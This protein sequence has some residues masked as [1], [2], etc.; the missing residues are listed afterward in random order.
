LRC[1]RTVQRCAGNAHVV[2]RHA[3]KKRL[4]EKQQEENG[5]RSQ[6]Q[7]RTD[8]ASLSEERQ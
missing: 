2:P 3:K 6:D 1:A 4:G 8:V 7:G 5:N